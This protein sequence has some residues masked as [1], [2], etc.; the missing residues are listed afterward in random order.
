MHH[1]GQGYCNNG[2]YA[3]WDGQGDESEE[4]CKIRCL[5]EPQCTFAAYYSGT[6][7]VKNGRKKTCSRYKDR[8]CQLISKR[9]LRSTLWPKYKAFE[10]SLDEVKGRLRYDT[11]HNVM[12][13]ILNKSFLIMK[14]QSIFHNYEIF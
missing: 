11:Y 14:S 13:I 2:F 1:F 7:I 6:K 4:A 9:T 10:K 12:K 3:G 8:K 5:V